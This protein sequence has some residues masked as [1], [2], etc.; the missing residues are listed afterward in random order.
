M[1]PVSL[2]L[3]AAVA[4]FAIGGSVAN[5]A[6]KSYGGVPYLDVKGSCED[7]QKFG[8][9]GQDKDVAYKGCMQD[10]MAAKSQLAKR[11]SSFKFA[12]KQ[13]C[14]EQARQPSP[15][16]VEVLTCLEMDTD[17]MSGGRNGHPKIGGPTPTGLPKHD[18]T[19]ADPP[20]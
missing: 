6:P 5:A 20:K 8:A 4:V 1:T 18:A 2:A 11:W 12:D 9:Q 10:E 13:T 15:S 19:K 14:V 17:G 7:A 16:Y 3:R